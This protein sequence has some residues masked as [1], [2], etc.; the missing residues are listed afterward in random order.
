MDG[1]LLNTHTGLIMDTLPLDC[2]H[3][4]NKVY[5]MLG[6]RIQ[7]KPEGVQVQ[8]RM[9]CLPSFKHAWLPPLSSL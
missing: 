6:R 5:V 9:K 2:L 4:S 7:A 3:I 8:T 1:A